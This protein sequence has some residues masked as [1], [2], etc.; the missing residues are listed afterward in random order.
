MYA[1]IAI[2]DSSGVVVPD[3]LFVN[4]DREN[5]CKDLSGSHEIRCQQLSQHLNPDRLERDGPCRSLPWSYSKAI[6]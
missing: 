3:Q 4:S 5:T 6:S 2:A 1:I